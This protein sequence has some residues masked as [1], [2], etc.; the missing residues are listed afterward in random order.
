MIYKVSYVV[1]DGS[2]PG[3]I[4][5]EMERPEVGNRVKIGRYEFEVV[6]VEE[7]MPPSGNFLYLHATVVPIAEVPQTSS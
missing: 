6:D 5:N 2:M 7:V 4:K 1:R 3:G